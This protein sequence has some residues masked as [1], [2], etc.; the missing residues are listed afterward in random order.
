M[1]IN[2]PEDLYEE[3]QAVA[4]TTAQPL[5][6]LVANRL[7]GLV[8]DP[9]AALPPDEQA[10]LIALR[11][12]SD[13]ALWTMAA[14]QMPDDAQARAHELL[15]K[16]ARGIISDAEAAELDGLIQRGD[17]LMVRKAEAAA[18]LRERGY[19]VQPHDLK[20]KP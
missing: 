18:I 1:L 20:P 2:I 4:N 10:E 6:E 13:D 19:Q 14:E 8:H 16:N 12:L 15:E 11:Y 5:E 7:K 17:R 9:F 3:L